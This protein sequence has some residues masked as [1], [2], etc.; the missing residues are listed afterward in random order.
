MTTGSETAPEASA[1]P[2]SRTERKSPQ[3]A[4]LSLLAA[5]AC[6]PMAKDEARKVLYAR[7]PPSTHLKLMR[8]VGLAIQDGEAATQ[9]SVVIALIDNAAVKKGKKPRGRAAGA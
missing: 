5:I 8:M 1:G 7:L 3:V 9:Q 2:N 6:A 4:L